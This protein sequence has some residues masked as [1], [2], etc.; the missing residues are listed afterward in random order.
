MLTRSEALNLVVMTC[1]AGRVGGSVILG[2][3]EKVTMKREHIVV[4]MNH[5]LFLGRTVSENFI[6]AVLLQCV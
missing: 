5:K 1:G 3:V 4:G 2:S 6:V